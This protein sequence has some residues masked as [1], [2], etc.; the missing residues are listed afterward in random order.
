MPD[1][2]LKPFTPLL[3]RLLLSALFLVS[4]TLKIVY[5][6]DT[7]QGLTAL[8]VPA[9]PFM[10]ALAVFAELAGGFAV[11]TGFL[12]RMA[13][14]LLFLYLIPVTLLFHAFW[15]S[16]AAQ[17]GGQM[18]QFLKN[19]AIMGGLLLLAAGGPGPLTLRLKRGTAP[20]PA[21]Q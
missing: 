5:W 20:P 10:L 18:I 19:L 2:P 3:G 17:Q 4:G 6:N 9:A 16:P 11:L 8:H 7:L 1:D 15:A 13:A 14:A 12:A 21:Q